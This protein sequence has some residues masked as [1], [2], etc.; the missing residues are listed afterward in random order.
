MKHLVSYQHEVD[1]GKLT[2]VASLKQADVSS[3]KRRRSKL[4]SPTE[5]SRSKRQL[6]LN[7]LWRLICPFQLHV[8]N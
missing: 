7:S 5:G 2:A 1:K 4:F 3:V 8:D 6:F